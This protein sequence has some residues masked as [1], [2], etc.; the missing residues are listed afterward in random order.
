MAEEKVAKTKVK[1][2]RWIQ[3]L[4]P[5]LFRNE[6]IGEI[7]VT[8]PQSLIK[9]A[10]TV[11][12]MS[13]TR[14]MKKQN[15]SIK[16]TIANI[17]GDKAITEF[18][19]YYLNP[20]SIKRLV[21]R[22]KEKI[23]ISIICK[24]SDNK[25]IRVMPLMIPFTKVKGSVA[26]AFK[27]NAA[28]YLTSYAAKT[29]F[30]NMIKDLITNKLQRELKGALKK[31]YPVRILE[32]AKLHIEKEKKPLEKKVEVKA[33]ERKEK[34]EEKVEEKKEEV[35][36]EVKETV[37]GKK[38]EEKKEEVK[39]EEKKIEEKPKKENKEEAPK[40]ENKEAPKK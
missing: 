2:K 30:E 23:G 15:T 25:K 19:G 40:E 32:I 1:K 35:E 39:K 4:S 5:E 24:T 31:I 29:T 17:K 34:V 11:N 3:I 8:E 27:K 36:K 6:L 13:L 12:L 21:R 20:T 38:A 22:G 14:D 7:P 33:E 28:D 26:T 37:E 10:I 9:R 16:F 18:Y